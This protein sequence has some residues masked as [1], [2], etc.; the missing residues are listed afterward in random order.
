M[1]HSRLL[2]SRTDIFLTKLNRNSMK[3]T[4]TKI[5]NI[6][7]FSTDVDTNEDDRSA[8]WQSNASELIKLKQTQSYYTES[9]L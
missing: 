8:E 2:K 4:V 9:F 7:V 1:N 6:F 5:N 3:N